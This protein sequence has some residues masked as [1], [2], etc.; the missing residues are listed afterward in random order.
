MLSLT[1]GQ[2][3]TLAS[4][5]P[6]SLARMPLLIRA[7]HAA[8]VATARKVGWARM[9]LSHSQIWPGHKADPRWQQGHPYLQLLTSLT[10]DAIT[11]WHS[12]QNARMVE[13]R[14]RK[15]CLQSPWPSDQ[16]TGSP[17]VQNTQASNTVAGAPSLPQSTLRC[18]CK[19]KVLR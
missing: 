12:F 9:S 17:F 3:Q 10:G 8:E 5:M 19:V 14:A 7:T 6:L 4:A 11:T 18:R 1:T 2:P 15:P 16:A 13:G